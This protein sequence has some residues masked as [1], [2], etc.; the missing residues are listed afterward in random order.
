MASGEP[1]TAAEFLPLVYRGLRKLAAARMAR[2]QPG[3]TLHATPLVHESYVRLV[4]STERASE[5]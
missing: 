1:Q 4:S 5:F 3:Q 2:L